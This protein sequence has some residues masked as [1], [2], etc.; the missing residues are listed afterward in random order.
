M[1][2]RAERPGAAITRADDPRITL[3]GRWLRRTKLDELPQFVNVVRGEM[4]VVGPRPEDPRFVAHYTAEQREVLRVLPGITSA[5]SLKYRDEE[6]LLVRDDWEDYYRAVVMP[7]KLR[8][9]LEYLK[10]RTFWSDLGILCATAGICQKSSWKDG[11][12]PVRPGS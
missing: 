6:R 12:P 1:R 7:D 11:A 10:R 5:A 9:E 3:I 2:V 4:S 8:I